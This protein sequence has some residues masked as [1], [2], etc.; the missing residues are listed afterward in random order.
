MLKLLCV[1]EMIN[2]RC[3][4]VV[5]NRGRN[6]AGGVTGAAAAAA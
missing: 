3:E 6:L 2:R 4:I 1:V 5:D